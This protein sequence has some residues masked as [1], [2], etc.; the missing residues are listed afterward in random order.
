[1]DNKV[2]TTLVR[3]FAEAGASTLRFNFR[4]VGGSGGEYDHGEGEGEDVRAALDWA[5]TQPGQADLPLWLAGFSFGSHVAARMAV[6]L[7]AARLLSIAPPVERWDFA[8]LPR[9]EGPW[10]V[11]QGDRDEVVDAAGVYRWL[12]TVQPPPVLVRMPEAT[13]FFHGLLV[14]LRTRLA[15]VWPA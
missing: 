14:E 13:H 12:A 1:M 7:G 4:G 5:R 6:P 2:V 9:I 15:E 10:V 8:Q 3:F 11:V